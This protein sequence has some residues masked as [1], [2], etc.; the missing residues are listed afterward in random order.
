LNQYYIAQELLKQI[1]VNGNPDLASWGGW[2]DVADKNLSPGTIL[3]PALTT[4]VGYGNSKLIETFLKAN[5]DVN[6]QNTRGGYTALHFAALSKNTTLVKELLARRANPN[7]AVSN[8]SQATDRGWTALDFALQAGDDE[9]ITLLVKAG[10]RATD[11][12]LLLSKSSSSAKT[13]WNPRLELMLNAGLNAADLPDPHALLAGASMEQAKTLLKLGLDPNRDDGRGNFLST[14]IANRNFDLAKLLL[15]AGAKPGGSPGNSPNSAPPRPGEIQKNNLLLSAAN[16]GA[17]LDLLE[18]LI[19]KGATP[20]EAGPRDGS[21]SFYSDHTPAGTRTLLFRHFKLPRMTASQDVR[22][23]YQSHNYPGVANLEDKSPSAHP[24]SLEELLVS[25]KV[26]VVWQIQHGK[27]G[28]EKITIWR[29]A[30]DG[31]RTALEADMRQD[32]AF[33]ALEWGDIVELSY[34]PE[35]QSVFSE[36]NTV[37]TQ[38]RLPDETTWKMRKRISFPITIEMNGRTRELTMRGDLV[39]FDPTRKEV[40]LMGAAQLARLFSGENPDMEIPETVGIIRQGWPEVRVIS[41]TAPN[42]DFALTRGDRLKWDLKNRAPQTA[43]NNVLLYSPGLPFALSFTGENLLIDDSVDRLARPTQPSL[44]QA[45]ATAYAPEQLKLKGAPTGS[46]ESLDGWLAGGFEQKILSVLPFPDLSK[47][48]IHRR[49]KDGGEKVIE[50]NLQQVCDAMTD[51][52]TTAEARQADVLLQAGDRVELPV[53]VEKDGKP[54]TG[55]S[56]SRAA[57]LGKAL[58]CTVQYEAN[59]GI[60]MRTIIYH[61]PHFMVTPGGVVPLPATEGDSSVLASDILTP[62]EYEASSQDGS[63][64]SLPGDRTF[65]SERFRYRL[66]QEYGSLPIG[67]QPARR[68]VRPPSNS[69]QP[70]PAPH[71]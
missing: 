69:N 52:T 45:I 48:R 13:N 29:T 4:A 49:I 54:W 5:P 6:L 2:G 46:P 33:P 15:D 66:T 59:G 71:R 26:P 18:E 25:P 35:D 19:A 24:K 39:I 62:G 16:N 21:W 22:V 56:A 53:A 14:A 32:T 7:L 17:P 27:L 40:P 42:G 68:I 61:P 8:S 30:P 31:T 1:D 57:L 10:G 11:P 28:P 3:G 50:V 34:R 70:Q 12:S 63:F 51:R 64:P 58:S 38:E 47:I 43:P 65:L 37:E 44:L 20:D 67:P 36:S 60:V 55:F 9:C 23:V 41:V